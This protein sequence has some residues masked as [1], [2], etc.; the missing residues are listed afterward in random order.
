MQVDNEYPIYAHV[1]LGDKDYAKFWERYLD[2]KESATY[3]SEKEGLEKI[4]KS[5][6]VILAYDKLMGYLRANPTD[7]KLYFFGHFRDP[8]RANMFCKN[9]PL[10]PIFNQGALYLR[11]NGIEHLIGHKWIGSYKQ[12][13]SIM[14]KTVLN[15]GQTVMAFVLLMGCFG[16]S[17]IILCG[18]VIFRKTKF[19]KA[20]KSKKKDKDK[21][22]TQR[23]QR[24]RGERLN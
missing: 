2:N 1:L 10:V 7:K 5:N 14:E 11:E 4:T 15:A 9:S 6:V 22:G 12:E 23:E 18:E 19:G 16:M 24:R 3:R 17:L 8:D 13:Y 20:V 21:N